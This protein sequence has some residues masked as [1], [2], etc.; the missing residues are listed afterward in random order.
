VGLT[1]R[2]DAKIIAVL[3]SVCYSG[4]PLVERRIASPLPDR[5]RKRKMYHTDVRNAIY[6][7]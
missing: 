4:S 1:I 7:G 5:G 2:T 3:K 6:E